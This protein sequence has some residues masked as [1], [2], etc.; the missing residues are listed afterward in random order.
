[1]LFFAQNKCKSANIGSST[2]VLLKLSDVA[3]QQFFF[4]CARDW[5]AKEAGPLLLFLC[6][7][8]NI[9]VPADDGARTVTGTR[10]TL[11]V[12]LIYS[13]ITW[14]RPDTYSNSKLIIKTYFYII[15]NASDYI[16]FQWKYY[17]IRLQGLIHILIQL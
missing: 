10:T 15:Q 7:R 14:W 13:S 9:R 6:F 5:Q 4:Q 17:N 1:M 3:D 2:A 12:A 8:E 16:L 11:W